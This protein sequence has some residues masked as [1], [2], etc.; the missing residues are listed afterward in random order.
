MM[1][2]EPLS[3]V[4]PSSK[5][6]SKIPLS[7]RLWGGVEEGW[8]GVEG[9]VVVVE[10]EEEEEEEGSRKGGGGAGRYPKLPE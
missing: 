8:G 5:R 1:K 3:A 2:M 10:E 7:R 6:Y 4:H 9:E